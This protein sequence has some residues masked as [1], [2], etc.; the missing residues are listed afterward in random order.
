[1][2]QNS[3]F[4]TICQRTIQDRLCFSSVSFQFLP[5]ILLH[6]FSPLSKPPFVFFPHGKQIAFTRAL[7][8][9]L[10]PCI[11]PSLQSTSLPLSKLEGTRLLSSVPCASSRNGVGALLVLTLTHGSLLLHPFEKPLLWHP[12]QSPPL[13]HWLLP[14]IL[15]TMSPLLKT[16]HLVSTLT[17]WVLLLFWVTSVLIGRRHLMPKSSNSSTTS[18]PRQSPFSLIPPTSWKHL[19]WPLTLRF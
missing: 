16:A 15:V 2:L 5:L 3:A 4:I 17:S 8:T 19:K 1:M 12:C 9:V 13:H 6:D 11:L 7:N 14:V 10:S 18:F